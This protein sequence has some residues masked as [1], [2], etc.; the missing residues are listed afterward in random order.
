MGITVYFCRIYLNAHLSSSIG[1]GVNE[2]IV[3]QQLCYPLD[4]VVTMGSEVLAATEVA[5][6]V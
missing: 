2:L 4:L 1:Q 3:S 5:H 6:L